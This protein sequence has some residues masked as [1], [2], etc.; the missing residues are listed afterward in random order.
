MDVFEFYE[1]QVRPTLQPVETKKEQD[2]EMWGNTGGE[3]KRDLSPEEI[4][5]VK[6]MLM[7][8]EGF[9]NSIKADLANNSTG[10]HEDGN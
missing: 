7:K 10:E 8:D 3:E 1:K 2:E 6:A 4:E 9:I 5:Q